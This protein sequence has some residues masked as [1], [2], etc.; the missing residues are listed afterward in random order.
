[1]AH[2]LAYSQVIS[3]VINSLCLEWDEE[4]GERVVARSSAVLSPLRIGGENDGTEFR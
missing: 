3:L 4:A 1:M 2:R